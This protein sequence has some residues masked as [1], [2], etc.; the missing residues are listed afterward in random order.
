MPKENDSEDRIKKLPYVSSELL[1]IDNEIVS[2]SLLEGEKNYFADLM[3]I[4]DTEAA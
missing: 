2:K 1:A 3:K 4:F